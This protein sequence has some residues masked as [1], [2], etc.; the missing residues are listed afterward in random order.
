MGC[1]PT[2]ARNRVTNG[3]YYCKKESYEWDAGLLLQE[4]ERTV[5]WGA[6]ALV[7]RTEETTSCE[8]TNCGRFTRKSIIQRIRQGLTSKVVSFLA[9]R[10]GWIV[11][12]AEE[13]STNS[14]RTKE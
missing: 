5:P 12:K 8:R 11:L 1:R 4:G 6:P 13:K 14:I 2:I 3:M 10:W 9:T 7:W